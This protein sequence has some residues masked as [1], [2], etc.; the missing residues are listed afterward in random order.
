[1]KISRSAFK[2]FIFLLVSFSLAYLLDG[3]VALLGG[4][5]RVPLI[6]STLLTA[7]M[8][9][10]FIGVVA[11]LSLSKT[12]IIDGLRRYGVGLGRGFAKWFLTAIA[13]PLGIAGLSVFYASLLSIPVRNPADLLVKQLGLSGVVD[14]NYLLI[15]VIASSMAA[16]ATINAIFAFG[17]EVGWRG[18]LLEELS[19][20]LG[21]FKAAAAIGVV[22]ASWHFPLILLFGYNYPENRLL[23]LAVYAGICAV[24][25]VILSIM[26]RES[27][28]VVHPSVMHGML[29]ALGG[30]LAI[31]I[32]IDRVLGAPVGLLSILSSLTVLAAIAFFTRRPRA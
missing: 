10:P 28:S 19:E 4:P 3:L 30:S 14:P 24:W 8:Y 23:G 2:V 7:R 20:K 15:I 26:K 12:R 31:S 21:F 13:A 18:L 1:M 6:Y 11:A 27:G 9:A 5:Q 17:E 29:N 25:S 16:G 32:P 22:W